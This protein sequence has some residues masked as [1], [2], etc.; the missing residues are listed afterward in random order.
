VG[1]LAAWSQI[2]G[3]A[4][5]DWPG[6]RSQAREANRGRYHF[7][8]T[9]FF[10][11]ACLRSGHSVAGA[12]PMTA[13][14]TALRSFAVVSMWRTLSAESEDVSGL[15][16]RVRRILREGFYGRFYALLERIG[17]I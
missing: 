13:P 7:T 4:A 16:D 8:T 2:A 14:A 1:S 12:N 3:L 5:S 15:M 9:R 11:A 6:T 17:M 10:D